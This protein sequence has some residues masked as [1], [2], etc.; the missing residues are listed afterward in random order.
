MLAK[1][2]YSDILKLSYLIKEYNFCKYK[3]SS[4]IKSIEFGSS[5]PIFFKRIV[6]KK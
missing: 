1:T 6:D 5:L 2:L 3:W 4:F